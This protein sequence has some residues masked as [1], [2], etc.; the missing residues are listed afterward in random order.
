M[1]S[2]IILLGV[3]ALFT[4]SSCASYNQERGAATGALLGGGAGAVIGHQFGKRDAG[5]LL[6]AT[7][8]AAG[9]LLHGQNQDR[10]QSYGAGGPRRSPNDDF[11]N[12]YR[13]PDQQYCRG[14][15]V[16]DAPSAYWLCK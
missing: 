16:W 6:G 1:K 10:L 2:L 5:A 7:L 15:W 12:P 11:R 3:L 14:Q 4:A 9:G 8:G 13:R